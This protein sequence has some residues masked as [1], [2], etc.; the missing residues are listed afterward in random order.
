MRKVWFGLFAFVLLGATA[1]FAKPASGEVVEPPPVYFFVYG[2]PFP[3]TM[4]PE[5]F[6]SERWKYQAPEV[7]RDVALRDGE[8]SSKLAHKPGVPIVLFQET[9][10]ADGLP[11]QTPRIRVSAEEIG[12]KP[13]FVY[14]TRRRL[15][16]NQSYLMLLLNEKKGGRLSWRA[17]SFGGLQYDAPSEASTRN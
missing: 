17:M 6:F 11:I 7:V 10:G 1:S 14:S 15:R 4:D 12:N 5:A 3:D 16:P 13:Q 2:W 8:L 9:L